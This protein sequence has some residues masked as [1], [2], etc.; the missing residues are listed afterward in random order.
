MK[1]EMERELTGWRKWLKGHPTL[2]GYAYAGLLCAA[3]AFEAVKRYW[4]HAGFAVLL[5]TL[6]YQLALL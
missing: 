1:L 6:G 3:V 2:F 5:V 4:P